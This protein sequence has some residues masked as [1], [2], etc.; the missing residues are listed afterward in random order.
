MRIP[1]FSGIF[2]PREGYR[3]AMCRKRVCAD[4]VPPLRMGTERPLAVFLLLYIEPVVFLGLCIA[5]VA[6]Y[7]F[8]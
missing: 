5:S 7:A 6:F 4:R 1:A 3:V 8:T 2:P